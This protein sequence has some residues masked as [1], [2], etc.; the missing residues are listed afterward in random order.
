MRHSD[1]KVDSGDMVEDV[2]QEIEEL[3]HRRSM[4][5]TQMSAEASAKRKE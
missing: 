4:S 1:G 2:E 3:R 5:T